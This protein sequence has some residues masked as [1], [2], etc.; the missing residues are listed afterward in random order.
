[1]QPM[2]ST[3]FDRNFASIEKFTYADAREAF[4]GRWSITNLS[5]VGLQLNKSFDKLVIGVVKF[6]SGVKNALNLI[7]DYCHDAD[8]YPVAHRLGEIGG[9]LGTSL[10]VGM[11]GKVVSDVLSVHEYLVAP[12]LNG[13]KLQKHYDDP[14]CDEAKKDVKG[15]IQIDKFVEGAITE[16][17][18]DVA[19]V[20]MLFGSNFALMTTAFASD[21]LYACNTCFKFVNFYTKNHAFDTLPQKV[22][23]YEERNHLI[24]CVI[25]ATFSMMSYC[26]GYALYLKAT[27][28]M[29]KLSPL[30]GRIK[31]FW[32]Y[33]PTFA[34]RVIIR[35][36]SV[37]RSIVYSDQAKLYKL[38]L[39]ATSSFVGLY[40]ALYKETFTRN[41]ND[42]LYQ[43]TE[44]Q[45]DHWGDVPD[46]FKNAA[47]S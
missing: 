41:L 36:A 8:K 16:Y 46:R 9:M 23:Y 47:T 24:M 22:A 26:I 35:V 14:N 32:K 42:N 40:A 28:Q 44:L 20:L 29:G 7:A 25:K 21:M 38:Y 18:G 34:K 12:L 10:K 30:L 1:M 3:P 2:Q 11:I 37:V 31:P 4:V 5:L 15:K 39:G 19:N 13:E 45:L 43:G 27:N 6:Q 17:A 33:L